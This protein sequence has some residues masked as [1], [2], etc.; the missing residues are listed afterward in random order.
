LFLSSKMPSEQEAEEACHDHAGGQLWERVEAGRFSEAQA[1]RIIREIL[2]L[3]AQAH[4]RNIVIRDIKPDNLLFLDHSEDAPLKAI[5]FGIATICTPDDILQERCGELCNLLTS[6]LVLPDVVL[7]RLTTP[8]ISHLAPCLPESRS[9]LCLRKTRTQSK[10]EAAS[11]Q[12]Y[13]GCHNH[14]NVSLI[15]NASKVW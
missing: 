7:T 12:S 13:G 6:H 5:D 4:S 8:L 2:Q 10:D 1:A 3:L 9:A 15:C 14:C 11:I